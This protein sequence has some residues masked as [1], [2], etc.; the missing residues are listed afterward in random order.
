LRSDRHGACGDDRAEGNTT[1]NGPEI[2]PPDPRSDT[3][4]TAPDADRATSTDDSG[5]SMSYRAASVYGGASMGYCAP[6]VGY[7]AASVGD[8]AASMGY[9]ATSA[10]AAAAS[11]HQNFNIGARGRR[12]QRGWRGHQSQALTGRAH[13]HER[14]AEHDGCD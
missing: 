10:G 1:N 9:C 6:S 5:A 8:P 7:C 2:R 3:P 11:A 4:G 13:H 12:Q 14:S